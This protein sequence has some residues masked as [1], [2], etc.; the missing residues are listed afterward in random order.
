[1]SGLLFDGTLETFY[2][3]LLASVITAIFGVPLGVLLLVTSRGYFWESPN[4]YRILGTI[5]NALR[6]IPFIILMV[7]II[8]FTK[9][10]VGTSIGTTAAIVPLTVSTIPFTGRL[11]ETSLR[12]VPYGL[13]E[14]ATSMGAT[15]W[16][17]IRRVLLPEAMPEIIQN[18]T[19]TVIVIIGSSAMA[20]TIGGGGLG[21]LAIRYGYMRFR[22]DMMIATVLI[23]IL[24]VQLVQWIGDMLS[25][26]YDHR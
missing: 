3:V 22:A 17:I 26:H 21:D 25:R 9:M 5:V 18:F 14:A 4:F 2:M 13:I 11:I 6:S 23:L 10:L 16:Q 20:G 15:P 12:T 19:I 1:M 8:P 7:A 24:M